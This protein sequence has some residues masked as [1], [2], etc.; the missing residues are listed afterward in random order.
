M[1][2]VL[3]ILLKNLTFKHSLDVE[4]DLEE[5]ESTRFKD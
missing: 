1:K 3:P 2:Q 4:I 5:K